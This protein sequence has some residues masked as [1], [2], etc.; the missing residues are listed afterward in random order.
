MLGTT[1][2][3]IQ[4]SHLIWAITPVGDAQMHAGCQRLAEPREV[5]GVAAP[6][7]ELHLAPDLAQR[8]P[9]PGENTGL[10]QELR[11]H[12]KR[13]RGVDG[14]LRA[15]AIGGLVLVRVL[16]AAGP[17]A[18]ILALWVRGTLAW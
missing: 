1:H 18:L 12:L 11:V 6:L 14:E 10:L 13:E 2:W 4:P 9:H 7:V 16:R 5:L 3:A 8:R 15:R 17:I